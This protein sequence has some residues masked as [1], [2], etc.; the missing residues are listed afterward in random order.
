MIVLSTAK[1]GLF[2]GIKQSRL[3]LYTYIYH[4]LHCLPKAHRNWGRVSPSTPAAC[5]Y[6]SSP[7]SLQDSLCTAMTGGEGVS[8]R[9]SAQH[10]SCF[11]REGQSH[12]RQSLPLQLSMRTQLC[13]F[14][15]IHKRR[16]D[17]SSSA[18]PDLLLF[19]TR[20]L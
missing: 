17:S 11:T 14:P 19:K 9:S 20:C 1:S 6:L 10:S 5:L 4:V 7:L 8:T 15:E 2:I 13:S 12:H 18:S 3:R 16:R